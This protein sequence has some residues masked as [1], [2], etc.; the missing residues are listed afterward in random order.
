MKFLKVKKDAQSASANIVCP[1]NKCINV[2]IQSKLTY[3]Q[4]N[5]DEVHFEI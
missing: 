1:W 3:G 5:K 2:K 4:R